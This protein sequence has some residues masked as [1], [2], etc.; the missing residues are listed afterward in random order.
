MAL[1]HVRTSVTK[2]CPPVGG[3]LLLQVARTIAGRGIAKERHHDQ[4]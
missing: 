2:K 3:W 4:Q 1:C